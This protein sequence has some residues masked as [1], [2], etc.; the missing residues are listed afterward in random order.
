MTIIFVCNFII[1]YKTVNNRDDTH[2]NG[3]QI[4][5]KKNVLTI[6]KLSVNNDQL[7]NNKGTT[8]FKSSSVDADKK[9]Q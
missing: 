9:S 4:Q 3:L 5:T 6:S 1:I 8:I 2:R 7:K